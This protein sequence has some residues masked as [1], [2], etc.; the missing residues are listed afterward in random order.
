DLGPCTDTRRP[1]VRRLIGFDYRPPLRYQPPRLQR[2]AHRMAGLRIPQT[3]LVSLRLVQVILQ[4][5]ISFRDACSGWRALVR[6]FGTPVP[7]QSDLWFPPTPE[8]LRRIASYQFVECGVLPQHGR[9]IVEA[10]RHSSRL[11]AAWDSGEAIDAA[12]KTC[13]LLRGIRGMGPWTI[14]HLRG[15]GLGDADAEVLGDYGH[16]KQ[17]GY[18]FDGEPCGDD[19]Q[20]LR[21]LE[22]YRPHRFYVLTLLVKGSPGPPRRGPRR[23]R[24][25]DRLR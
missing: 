15:N 9:R 17:V 18:F 8:S 5:M 13:A 12:D 19:A 25:R 24:L 7:G 16:P 10:M 3:P 23:G 2:L 11:E 1:Q 4:Q 6:R 21:L 14:G 22:P 20:M